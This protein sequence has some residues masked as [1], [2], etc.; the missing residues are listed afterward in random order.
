MLHRWRLAFAR[1]AACLED[2][3]RL[4]LG[5]LLIW[6]P[7]HEVLGT[8]FAAN[9]QKLSVDS[10]AAGVAVVRSFGCVSESGIAMAAALAALFT[11]LYCRRAGL[12]RIG[13]AAA[14]WTFACAGYF[15]SLMVMAGH[16]P[17]LE[18]YPAL[19]LLLW[20][21]DRALDGVQGGLLSLG[22]AGD[23][24]RLRGVGRAS[25]GAGSM[26]WGR[27]CLYALWRGPSCG[28]QLCAWR[29]QRWCWGSG[30]RWRS[31]GRC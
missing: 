20:L 11:Y 6:N 1:Q 31:G 16:L 18:A 13:A 24:L 4:A 19:P 3:R 30:W 10:H 14:G 25:A 17:L 8:P 23:L 26:P 15:S 2:H 12:T 28:I 22:G 27:R 5:G 29:R 9:L 21:A 7:P